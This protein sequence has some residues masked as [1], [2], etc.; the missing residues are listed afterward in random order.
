MPVVLVSHFEP[1]FGHAEDRFGV[2]RGEDHVV[3]IHLCV[4]GELLRDHHLPLLVHLEGFG[5]FDAVFDN[6]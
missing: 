6:S 4:G 5:N 1:H 3:R 2:A